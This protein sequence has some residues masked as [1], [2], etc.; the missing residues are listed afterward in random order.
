[1][2]A[3]YYTVFTAKNRD[4]K[5]RVLHAKVKGQKAAIAK[6]KQYHEEHPDRYVGVFEVARVRVYKPKR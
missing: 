5:P 3:R 4:A 1:M 6:A 2:E